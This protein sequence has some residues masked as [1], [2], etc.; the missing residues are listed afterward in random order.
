MTVELWQGPDNCPQKLSVYLEDGA[1]RP[2]V[3]FFSTPFGGNSVS[4]RNTAQLEYPL[5]AVLEAGAIQPSSSSSDLQHK[6][7][8]LQHAKSQTI[9]GGAVMTKPFEP[10][11]KSV[12]VFLNT[13]G[14]PLNCRMELLQGPNNVKQVMEVYTEDGAVRPF[15]SIVQTPGVGNV[16]RIVNTATLEFPIQATVEPWEI[17]DDDEFWMIT[18]SGL[19]DKPLFQMGGTQTWTST[20]FLDNK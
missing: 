10:N 20:F 12:Q 18:G 9:Q 6:I 2:F 4:I 5:Q 17:A 11:V 13:E 8:V 14:R 15:Y 16:M 1:L 19:E 3:C 7:N